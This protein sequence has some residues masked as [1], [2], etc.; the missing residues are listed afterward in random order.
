MAKTNSNEIENFR[1]KKD[2]SRGIFLNVKILK[3]L[4]H[5]LEGEIV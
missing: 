4:K 3:G 1:T 5:S 2:I